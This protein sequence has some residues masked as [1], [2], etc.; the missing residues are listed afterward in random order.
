MDVLVT[1]ATGFVGPHLLQRLLARGDVIRVLA[2][3]E[4]VEQVRYRDRVEVVVGD[5]ADEVVLAEAVRGAE[6]V[7]HLA[8]R[9][10]GSHEADLRVVNVGGTE[11]LLRACGQAGGVRRFVFTSSVMVYRPAPWPHL[12]PISEN[13]PRQAHGDEAM[14]SYGQSKIDAEDVVLRAHQGQGFEY[15]I[16]RPT[17]AYGPGAPTIEGMLRQVLGRPRLALTGGGALG[18]MQWVHVVDLADAVAL[19]GSRPRAAN[20]VFN[21]AGGEAS[22]IGEVAAT[23][24]DIFDPAAPPHAR[25]FS[26]P[27]RRGEGLKFDIG[28]AEVLLGF[29][30]RVQLREGLEEVVATM[31]LRA[32]AGTPAPG[33]PGRGAGSA[34]WATDAAAWG[35]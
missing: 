27:P 17:L 30:P 22:G 25:R 9:P 8:E 28:K 35:W 34:P 4:T 24:W 20:E 33:Q 15:V 26:V 19:S 21:V 32:V 1:G 23:L 29:V 31:D 14:W 5:L 13:W 3:P 18:A 10:L 12:W 2:L 7:Y 16:L 11:K 6:V